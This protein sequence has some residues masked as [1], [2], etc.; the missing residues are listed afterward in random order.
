MQTAKNQLGY[1]SIVTVF[2]NAI[3]IYRDVKRA[4][5]DGLQAQDALV[6]WTSYPKGKQ[7]YLHAEEAYK[8]FIDLVPEESQAVVKAVSEA[9]GEPG[10]LVE[11]KIR[12]ILQ[13][14]ADTHSYVDT[15]Y[16]NGRILLQRWKDEFDGPVDSAP[17]EEFVL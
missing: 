12:R 16:R 17:M 11:A 4:L 5:A 15:T 6:L 14:C 9:T 7:V 1:D 13:L 3:L 8:E 2:T 10:S